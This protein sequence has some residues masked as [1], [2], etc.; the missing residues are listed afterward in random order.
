MIRFIGEDS[1]IGKI[2]L[3]S[4]GIGRDLY[5]KLF[6][7]LTSTKQNYHE[8]GEDLFIHDIV[9]NTVCA[10]LLDYLPRDSYFC[11]LPVGLDYRFLNYLYLFDDQIRSEEHTSELQSRQY[12][13]C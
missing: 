8:L 7:I 12:L 3:G 2:L 9:S 11:D 6:K 1:N 5:K 4:N 10:D 13:V